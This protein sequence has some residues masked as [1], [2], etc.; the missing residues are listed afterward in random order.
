MNEEG[1]G[2]EALELEE[3]P[4]IECETEISEKPIIENIEMVYDEENNDDDETIKIRDDRSDDSLVSFTDDE[5]ETKKVAI[6]KLRLDLIDKTEEPIIEKRLD[7][8][9]SV[10]ESIESES[11]LESIESESVLESIESESIHSE[12]I[13]S[14]SE[15]YKKEEETMIFIKDF[16]VQA[17]CLEKCHGTLDELF[18]KGMMNESMS[19]SYIFQ[20]IMILMTYQKVFGMTHNDLHT[21]NI[22]FIETEVEYLYYKCFG[23][24]FRVPTYG[25]IMKI[26][27]FGRSIYSYDGH[28][29]TSDSF[30][31]EG[32]AYSQYNVEPYYNPRKPRIKPSFSFDL[33]RLGTSI[34]DFI[35]DHDEDKDS[36]PET[37]DSFQRIIL[38]WCL[39]DEGRNVLYKKSGEERYPEFKLYNMIARTVSKHTPENQLRH[40]TEYEYEEPETEDEELMK[41][42]H[43]LPWINIDE[44]PRMV[45]KLL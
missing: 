45:D 32:D 22:M 33:C 13:H 21:N 43:H 44:I 17:I 1:L 12:S 11:V 35:F 30:S 28:L 4:E 9:E 38:E 26:I 36:N 37:F 16:P 6:P 19:M 42:D 10:W 15:T 27:D 2:I 23:K 8:E 34:Y 20:V 41:S 39:D 40:F 31:P 25:R 7:E 24:R 18:D 5:E 3:C 29:F 14:D